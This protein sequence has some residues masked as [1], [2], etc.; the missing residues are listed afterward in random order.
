[1]FVA[2]LIVLA[3]LSAPRGS[4]AL[5]LLEAQTRALENDPAG[6]ALQW[7]AR[8]LDEEA[9][10]AG[11]RPNPDWAIEVENF[12]GSDAF[13]GL[14]A[15]EISGTLSQP[16]ELG[17]KRGRRVDVARAERDLA[18]SDAEIRQLNLLTDVTRAFVRVLEAQEALRITEE[19]VRLGDE[20]LHAVE[21]R[22]KGGGASPVEVTRAHVSLETARVD[23]ESAS[24]TLAAARAALAATWNDPLA[25]FGEAQG[26]LTLPPPLPP[27]RDLLA[28]LEENPAV[29]RWNVVRRRQ[30]ARRA[31]EASRG[32]PNLTLGGGVRRLQG[33]DDT[34]FLFNVGSALPLFDRNRAATRAEELRI[35]GIK[36][37]ERAFRRDVLVDLTIHHEMFR[38]G[39]EEASR[40]RDTVLP[41]AERA[42][43]AARDAYQKG[44]FRYTDVLDTQRTLFDLR[45]RYF[46]S[47]ARA[48]DSRAEIG[49]LLGEPLRML[50]AEEGSR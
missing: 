10:Q 13:S 35:E 47:L 41:E 50:G 23:R 43:T 39:F 49:R 1:M 15:A 33:S 4:A 16:L 32:A 31:L 24:R 17:S 34:A 44:L 37:E 20:E 28:R 7:E 46:N 8:A 18:T 25:S 19:I 6:L 2:L 11:A 21:L 45:L 27:L 22:V 40:L 26:D 12:A 14:D 9:E 36:E 3:L 29:V 5:T 42:Y 38:S 48:Q 30:E